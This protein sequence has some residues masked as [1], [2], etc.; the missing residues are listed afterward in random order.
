MAWDIAS[1]LILIRSGQMLAA[2]VCAAVN[3][4]LLGLIYLKHL[5][6]TSTLVALEATVR[7]LQCCCL[8]VSMSRSDIEASGSFFHWVAS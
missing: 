2:F 5:G 6:F 3:G 7:I 8:D 4:Y 1:W